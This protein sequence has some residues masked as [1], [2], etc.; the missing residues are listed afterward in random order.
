M[1]INYEKIISILNEFSI[2]QNTKKHLNKIES[3][4]IDKRIPCLELYEFELKGYKPDGTTIHSFTR[5]SDSP[6]NT[7]GSIK[8]TND[9]YSVIKSSSCDIISSE[10][11]S[12]GK[13]THEDFYRMYMKF[14]ARGPINN[15][16]YKSENI[17]NYIKSLIMKTTVTNLEYISNYLLKSTIKHDDA[18][19]YKINVKN[20]EKIVIFG[21]FHGSYHT[22]YRHILRLRKLGIIKSLNNWTIEDGYRLIFLGDI[23]DRGVYALEILTIICE[24]IQANNT[25]EHLKIIYNRGNHE[26]ESEYKYYGF[27]KEYGAKID[28]EMDIIKDFYTYSP[29]A[30]IIENEDGFRYWL[31]HGG[32]PYN[33]SENKDIKIDDSMIVHIDDTN[34]SRQIRWND[35]KNNTINS[36][37]D[38]SEIRGAGMISISPKGVKDFNE[39]NNI[40]FII[41]GHEDYPDNSW[42]LA[43]LDRYIPGKRVVDL[44]KNNTQEYNHP[45]NDV[46]FINANYINNIESGQHIAV[47]GPV[48][49]IVLNGKSW[50]YDKNKGGHKISYNDIIY[51]VITLSTNNDISR[52]LNYD[53]FGILRFDLR[54]DQLNNF[55]KET[56]IIDNRNS[57]FTL[58]N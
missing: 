22:F 2:L 16:E 26:K 56:N 43:N 46:V 53:S 49:R 44:A 34:I 6:I 20:H 50:N 11:M 45:E 48:S 51:P 21:D 35:F 39:L 8:V 7:C 30:I 9:K 32:I 15:S 1:M 28:Y 36:W 14:P 17:K 27:K 18:L 3:E 58:F 12:G 19:I 47:Q 33:I 4:Y 55:D 5:L 38:N 10:S 41:R 29:S 52:P 13:F 42:I 23:L 31:S 37:A 40:Q 57:S 25:K 24:L 54:K